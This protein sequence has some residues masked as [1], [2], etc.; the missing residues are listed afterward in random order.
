MAFRQ[1]LHCLLGQ[2]QSLE[3]E[4]Q[5][6]LDIIACDPS[7]YTMDHLKFI[8]S[9]QKEESIACSTQRVIQVYAKSDF[10][11]VSL[12]CY[13]SIKKSPLWQLDGE[14]SNQPGLN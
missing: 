13:V 9:N 4:I 11:I 14:D 2:K 1:G 6:C 8:V 3:K 10:L 5:Y 7:I 12:L